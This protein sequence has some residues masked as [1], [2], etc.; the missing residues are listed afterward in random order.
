MIKLKG[1]HVDTIEVIN[2]GS[3]A[4]LNTFTEYDFQDAFKKGR[5]AGNGAYA[6]KGITSRVMAASKPKL[7]FDQMGAR[8]PE[9]MNGSL[10]R[11]SIVHS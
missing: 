10:S 6:W 5:C 1:S 8:V 3:H 2:A 7:V 11:H 4:L 9:I